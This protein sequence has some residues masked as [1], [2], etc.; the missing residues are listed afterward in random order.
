MVQTKLN[1]WPRKLV[2]SGISLQRY[3]CTENG[4]IS[5]ELDCHPHSGFAICRVC[6]WFV[7]SSGKEV[8]RVMPILRLRTQSSRRSVNHSADLTGELH[9]ELKAI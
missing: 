7:L 4:K 6:C 3:N 2:C 5:E 1:L 9:G 8:G